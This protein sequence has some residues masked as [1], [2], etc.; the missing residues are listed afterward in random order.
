MKSFFA[1]RNGDSLRE[2]RLGVVMS[3]LRRR[4]DRCSFPTSP[5]DTIWAPVAESP[6]LPPAR[7][8]VLQCRIGPTFCSTAS[9]QTF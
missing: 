9:I 4:Y 8:G 5:V 3:G 6:A 1:V 2:M 7:S